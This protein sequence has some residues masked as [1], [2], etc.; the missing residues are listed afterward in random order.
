MPQQQQQQQRSVQAASSAAALDVDSC[1]HC[2][3]HSGCVVLCLCAGKQVFVPLVEDQSSNMSMLHIGKL[4]NQATYAC[5]ILLP[6]SCQPGYM[7][8]GIEGIS[9]LIHQAVCTYEA[10]NQLCVTPTVL[11]HRMK[12]MTGSGAIAV[13]YTHRAYHC[14]RCRHATG[15]TPSA[16]IWNIGAQPQPPRRQP[17]NGRYAACGII[18]CHQL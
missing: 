14:R 17:Q 11:Y 7:S 1:S 12:P 9:S 18:S 4:C 3:V 8:G 2:W 16:P 13:T 10:Q 15:P 6:H 5:P